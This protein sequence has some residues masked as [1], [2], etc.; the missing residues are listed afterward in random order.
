M[1]VSR[2]FRVVWGVLRAGENVNGYL[3]DYA[4]VYC[5]FFC[6]SCRYRRFVF[7]SLDVRCA[8]VRVTVARL[9]RVPRFSDRKVGVLCWGPSHLSN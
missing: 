1:S 9:E 4:G 3:L 8:F 7:V 2:V 5:W 6:F